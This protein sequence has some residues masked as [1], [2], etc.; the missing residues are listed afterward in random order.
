MGL[1]STSPPRGD[2]SELGIEPMSLA[3]AGRFLTT[4]PPGKSLYVPCVALDFAFLTPVR[5]HFVSVALSEGSPYEL[6]WPWKFSP[7]PQI[8]WSS[9]KPCGLYSVPA[10]LQTFLAFLPRSLLRNSSQFPGLPVIE[11]LR[12]VC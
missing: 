6:I 1:V 10:H 5:M 3:L 11:T 4:G 7:V 9:W 8:H 12:C 2:S